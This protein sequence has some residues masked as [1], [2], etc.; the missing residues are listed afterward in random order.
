MKFTVSTRS[1]YYQ[2]FYSVF[3]APV[4]FI[5]PHSWRRESVNDNFNPCQTTVSVHFAFNDN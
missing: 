4:L 3:M 5:Q 1:D 2:E